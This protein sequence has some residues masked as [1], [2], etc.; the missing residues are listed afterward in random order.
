MTASSESRIS[1]RHERKKLK[2][3]VTAHGTMRDR[4]IAAT[5]Q[6]ALYVN[7]ADLP[8]DPARDLALYGHPKAIRHFA[9]CFDRETSLHEI[10]FL[11]P[12]GNGPH[13]KWRTIPIFELGS[14]PT[15]RIT[16]CWSGDRVFDFMLEGATRL[17]EFEPEND[18]G[19][20]RRGFAAETLGLLGLLP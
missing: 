10:E 3:Q 17:S 1:R 4:I 15:D 13:Y 20:A 11:P 19:K 9:I 16:L 12:A 7:Q 2:R 6:L 5:E 14:E 8:I 18:H